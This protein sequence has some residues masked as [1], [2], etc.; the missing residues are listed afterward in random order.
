MMAGRRGETEFMVVLLDRQANIEAKDE[1]IFPQFYF[2]IVPFRPLL[3]SV[4]RADG[5][6]GV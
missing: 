6:D 1:V 4:E 3:S 5:P 2:F